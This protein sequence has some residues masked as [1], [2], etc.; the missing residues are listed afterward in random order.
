M[1]ASG[2]ALDHPASIEALADSLSLC[3]DELHARIMKAIT[4]RTATGKPARLDQSISQEAA[5]A[6]FATEVELRQRANG[7]YMAAA[8]HAAFGLE[9]ARQN[10]L[11]VTHAMQQ[12][13]RQINRLQDLIGIGADLLEFAAAAA[14]GNPDHLLSAL[15]AM[16]QHALQAEPAPNEQNGHS[17]L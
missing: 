11:A 13:I 17:P 6:L 4:A 7:L 16:R 3:A 15:T 14:S 10:A 9:L 5:Q 12:K 2:Q 8:A 1:T